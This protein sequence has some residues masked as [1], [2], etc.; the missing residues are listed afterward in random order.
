G[1]VEGTVSSLGL[2]YTNLSRG[3]ETIMIPN[4]VVLSS[5]VVPLREPDSLSLRAHLRPDVTPS[6]VQALLD[7]HVTIPTRS[8][9]HIGL[10]SVDA[11]EVVVRIAATPTN[12]EDGPRLADEILAA[13]AGVTAG[14]ET[15]SEP[16]R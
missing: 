14:G 5:V 8:E 12:E 4:N 11:D 9:P 1:K 10:E 15:N 16:A 6:E 2:L 3:D 13:V 7:E